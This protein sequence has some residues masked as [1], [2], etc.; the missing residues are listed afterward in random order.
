MQRGPAPSYDH[1]EVARLYL[2]GGRQPTSFVAQHMGVS[3]NI[4]AKRV[5]RVRELGLLP[6]AERGHA[7]WAEHH[8]VLAV[9]ARGTKDQRQWTVCLSCLTRWPC[10]K[11]KGEKA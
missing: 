3:R 4:A 2:A 9:A 6:P 10:K 1:A 8:P 11:S 5:K 7:T